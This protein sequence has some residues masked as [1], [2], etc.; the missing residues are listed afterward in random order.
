ML[1]AFVKIPAFSLHAFPTCKGF[2]SLGCHDGY[3]VPNLVQRE[4]K[5]NFGL[6]PEMGMVR[7]H[8]RLNPYWKRVFSPEMTSW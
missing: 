1:A 7:A 2:G 5:M 3:L 6:T 4:N 8:A